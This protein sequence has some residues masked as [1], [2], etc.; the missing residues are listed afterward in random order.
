MILAGAVAGQGETSIVITIA[1]V[2]FCAWA[3]DTTSFFIGR[4]LGREF[5][6]R[7]GAEGAD[8]ARALR[9]G[10]G[11][12]RPPR[13]QDD[14]DRALHRP[15]PGA[16]AV[17]RRQLGDAATGRSSPTACS[18]PGCGRRRS[19][20]SATSLANSLDKATEIAGTGALLFGSMVA[21]I[22]GGFVI[23]RYLREPENR[24]K[25]ARADRVD[26]RAAGGGWLAAGAVPLE[27]AHAGRPRARVHDPDRGPRR[28]RCSC[29]SATRSWSPAT[30]GRPRAT[31]RRS[32]S[33]TACA[34][35]GSPTSPKVVTAL[36]SAAVADPGGAGRR[37]SCS[38]WRRRWTEVGVLVGGDGDHPDR[39]SPVIKE[40]VDRPRPAGGL[41]DAAG[42]AYPSG[43]AAHSVIYA[44]LA[45]TI[46]VRL[47]PGWTCGTALIVAG[48]RA[49]R[50]GRAH[51]ASTSA[52]TTSATSAAA[53]RWACPR[54]PAAP[55]SRWRSR[56]CARLRQNPPEARIHDLAAAK[57]GTEY[58]LFGGAGADQPARVRG[59][60]PGR[61]RS[62]PS[63]APGRRRPRCLVSFFVLV[64]LLALGVA[65]GVAI[66]Y[67]WDDISS[68]SAA[69][70]AAITPSRIARCPRSR[71]R[72]RPPRKTAD[73]ATL[74]ALSEAIESGAGLPAV[75]RAAAEALGASVALIDRSSAVLAVAAASSAEE[76][77]L[78]SGGGGRRVAASCG[79]PTR[80][81]ASCATGPAAGQPSTRRC[82][83]WSRPCWRSSSS[84]R[85]RRTGRATRRRA[86]SS[87][88]CSSAG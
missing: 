25:L 43:H 38:A 15:G 78:L 57:I 86:S 60:D 67:Y 2:W 87:A 24:R 6:L 80:S 61:P 83:G 46:A 3:G 74:E 71:R 41:V 7:H 58:L 30:P 44:W 11:L 55:R 45:L 19:R 10:R 64:A 76:G 17:H 63:G 14:P 33:S 62:A 73:A 31:A 20:C 82:C 47:R 39:A 22:V 65:V 70:H 77:K 12:L 49:R 42:Y 72:G 27:P 56:T 53:G 66:V 59:A 52:S 16:G 69:E 88:R 51:A 35:A 54:S 29:S 1:I 23:S 40:V 5:M 9:A 84:A 81:S 21:V 68:S 13:R 34:P 37:R 32:T 85:A 48:I 8:H 79:S 75:A 26:A 18:A 36:G 28:S 4:R 50:G